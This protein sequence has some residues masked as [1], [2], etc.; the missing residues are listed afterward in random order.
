MKFEESGCKK[1][2]RLR[3]TF[4]Y[5]LL[6]DE[7]VIYVGQTK[8]G[9]SRLSAHG[10]KDYDEIYV[11]YCDDSELDYLEDKYITK[12]KPK[13]NKQPNYYMNISMQRVKK[14]AR[15]YSG[16]DNLNIYTVR[17]VCK[18]LEIEPFAI[19]ATVYVK[20]P[21][22]VRIVRFIVENEAQSCDIR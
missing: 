13:Y 10:D 19:N 14:A 6:K 22:A 17:R 5:F 3:E 9:I 20:C 21:D 16:I 11:M 18:A 7:E 8:A 2:E 15:R 4:V 1:I 12:Y